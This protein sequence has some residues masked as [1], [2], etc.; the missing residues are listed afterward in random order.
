[1]YPACS[2]CPVPAHGLPPRSTGQWLAASALLRS[3]PALYSAS[4]N[5]PFPLVPSVV[6]SLISAGVHLRLLSL[7]VQCF[8]SLGPFVR[9]F[10]RSFVLLLPRAPR[11]FGDFNARDSSSFLVPLRLCF[12]SLF[13]TRPHPHRD[14][15][16]SAPLFS[17][18]LV[19]PSPSQSGRV[20][21][22]NR[23]F[24]SDAFRLPIVVSP[25]RQIDTWSCGLL[26][27]SFPRVLSGFAIGD[28]CD[29][30]DSSFLIVFGRLS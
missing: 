25:S 10:R 21:T 22:V 24:R 17:A 7:R 23:Y 18:A 2:S 28:M 30:I 5:L 6:P 26:S 13:R 27:V 4:Y 15:R 19:P 20:S 1:M 9:S 8:A 3:T 12:L 14:T 29:R 16:A 11:R